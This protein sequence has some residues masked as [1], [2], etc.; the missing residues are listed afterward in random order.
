MKL[1]FSGGA[2]RWKMRIFRG[3]SE[4]TTANSDAICQAMESPAAH[5]VL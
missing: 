4:P 1:Q 3:N 5:W 2:V